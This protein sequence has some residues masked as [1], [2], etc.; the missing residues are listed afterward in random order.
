[1]DQNNVLV[2]STQWED[3]EKKKPYKNTYTNS[4]QEHECGLKYFW[5]ATRHGHFCAWLLPGLGV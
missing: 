1:M 4:L 5:G 3:P 2:W